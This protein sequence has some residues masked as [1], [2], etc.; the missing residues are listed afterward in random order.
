[1][2]NRKITF[3][4]IQQRLRLNKPWDSVIIIALSLLAAI[5]IFLIAHQNLL[6]PEWYF[7]FDRI[8]IFLVIL[9]LLYLVFFYLRA[10]IVACIIFFLVMLLYGSTFGQYGFFQVY[11]DYRAMIYTMADDPHPQDLILSK[12]LPFPNK[13]RI[14]DAVEYD[15]PR[16]RNFAIMTTTRH[17]RDVKNAGRYRLLVQ[18]FAAFMEI[19]GRWNYVNDPKGRDYIARASESLLHF[20]GDCDDHAILMAAC[21]RAIG[22]TPRLIHTTGHIYPEILI[23]DKSDLESVN[24]LI[25][26][27]LFVEQA[28]DQELAMKHE[29]APAK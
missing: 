19:N 2:E 10:L 18:C 4:G 21:V 17:F 15:N 1:M 23:G 14:I 26:K 16:V 5:P 3:A 29:P 24:Y 12:L 27:V 22:G 20:S 8:L 7:Q 9:T 28:K 11:D 25:K 13:S 6:D